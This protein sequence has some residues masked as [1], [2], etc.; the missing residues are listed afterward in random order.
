MTMTIHHVISYV[1]PATKKEK[2]SP[3]LPSVISVETGN[4]L[5]LD[6]MTSPPHNGITFS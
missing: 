4:L 1:F 5:L 6:G 2:T 3:S